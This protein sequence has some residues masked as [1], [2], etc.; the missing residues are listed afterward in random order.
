MNPKYCSGGYGL[1][2]EEVVVMKPTN[3]EVN[4]NGEIIKNLIIPYEKEINGEMYKITEVYLFVTGD[5]GGTPK[6]KTIIFPNTVTKITKGDGYYNNYKETLTKV[7][8]P[9]NLMGLGDLFTGCSYLQSINLPNSLQK[10]ED[11]T[12]S[13]CNSLTNIT[14]PENVIRIGDE[15]FIQC[16]SLK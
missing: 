11:N 4:Y 12:F 5:G 13:C 1:W 2:I 10:I 6:V 14:I 15:A 8:L 9:N 3:Y 16:Y 7:V